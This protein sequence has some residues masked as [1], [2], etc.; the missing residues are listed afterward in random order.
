MKRN[1]LVSACAVLAGLSLVGVAAAATWSPAGNLTLGRTPEA[2]L[3]ADGRVLVTGGATSVGNTYDTKLAEIYDPST[4]SWSPTG[5]TT[6]GRTDHTATRLADGRVLV[7]GGENS[8]ICTNDVTTELY[9]PSSGTW[10]F[11]G[12]ANVARTGATAT[13]LTNGKVLL[14]GGGNRCGTV[15]SSAE[16]YDPLTGTWTSTGSM[17]TGRE[18]AAAVRLLN[19]KVLVVGGEGP[20][21]FPALTTAELYDPGTGTWSATGSMVT[22]RCCASSHW[23]VLLADGRVLA[24]GGNSGFANFTMPNGPFAEVYD[25]S[26]G[27][28]TPT[29]SMSSARSG[30]T[31]SL[32]A[33]GTVLTAGGYDGTNTL[34]SAELWDPATGTWS[35]TAS[36][37]AARG[38]HTATALNNGK[39]LVATGYDGSYLTSAELY[40]SFTY[41][42]TGFFQ[43]VDNAPTF[44]RVKAGSGV[45]VKFSLGGDQGLDVFATGYPKSEKVDCSS[46][47]SLDDIEQTVTA[48]GSSLSYNAAAD[49]YTYTWKTDKTWSGTCRKLTV[50]LAD[51]SDHTAYFAFTR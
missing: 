36:L 21:P 47:G 5:S 13:L 27:L 6:N 25:P 32:L 31:L 44:N 19:G 39:V 35:L 18:W 15:F 8:N 4:N 2:A 30:N 14:A 51:G 24:A 29:G 41:A 10:S 40:T 17:T 23:I 43:P 1:A 42:F 33:N 3:L 46:S 37:L 50:R 7:A 45:P 22:A 11:T 9:D 28:W 16:L 49:Q 34:S 38:G 48:G 26:T 12:N 20:N